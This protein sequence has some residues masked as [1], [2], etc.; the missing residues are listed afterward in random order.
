MECGS[1]STAGLAFPV[2]RAAELASTQADILQP[3]AGAGCV[4]VETDTIVAHAELPETVH[5]RN[6]GFD[7]R[8]VRMFRNISGRLFIKQ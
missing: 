3:I 7:T 4:S 8:G 2:Q 5:L 1:C 6:S